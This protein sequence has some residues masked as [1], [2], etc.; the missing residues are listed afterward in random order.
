MTDHPLALLRDTLRPHFN[1]TKSRLETM[2]VI[3]SGMVNNRTVNLSHLT[4]QFPGNATPRSNYRR[5][6]RFF[7]D[8]Q[9]DES[10]VAG[11]TTSLLGF[12]GPKH[13]AI[14]RTNWKLGKTDI[15]MLVLAIV[16]PKFKIPIMCTQ[17]DHRGNSSTEQ[18]IDLMNRYIDIFG[19]S[20]IQS[21]LGD[22]EFVGDK[23][24]A[25]LIENKIPFDIRL[26]KDMHIETEDEREFQFSSLLRKYR[27]G[28]WKGWLCGMARTPENLLR[29]EGKKIDG[30]LIVVVTNIPAPKNALNLYRKRWGIECLF[31]D[32]KTRGLN[33]EDTHMT[34]HIKL[35]T[36]LNMLTLSIVWAYRCAS[37]KMGRKGI[38][39]KPHGRREQSWFRLGL[40]L[41]RK[42]IRFDLKEAFRAWRKHCPE[43]PLTNLCRMAI[44]K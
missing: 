30:E 16:T 14:D 10:A 3:I 37:Q 23:W 34:N 7:K 19:V 24:F 1:L 21:L 32:L 4:S 20:S 5:L 42:W 25:Y 29:F 28:Q 27:R 41:L 17:L 8:I 36:L 2:A 22:R 26:R 43:Q 15:N 31:A 33:I 11:L 44:L 13:L 40:D 18:R 38:K 39:R 35:T 6:Q 9:L 12:D